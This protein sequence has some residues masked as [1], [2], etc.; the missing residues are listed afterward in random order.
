ML[1]VFVSL[2][3]LTVAMA[4]TEC[5]IKA[6]DGDFNY[7]PHSG[8]GPSNWG[9]MKGYEMCSK[10]TTQ[11]P[12]DFPADVSYAPLTNGPDPKGLGGMMTLQGK[13][14]NFELYCKNPG[15]CGYTLFAGKNFSVVNI[16]FHA[17][18]EHKLNGVQYPLEAHVVHA[19]DD[20]QLAVISTMFQYL[21]GDDYHSKLCRSKPVE[22][23]TNLLMSS[24]FKNINQGKTTFFVNIKTIIN[25][26]LGY[27]SYLG[28]LTTPPCT[29]GVTFFMAND[30]KYINPRQ[31]HMYNVTA[32]ANFDGNNR[33]TQPLNGRQIVC[34]M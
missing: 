15:E 12:V 10:G 26:P 8:H 20:G 19:S 14:S 5:R 16:H 34:F 6:K 25:Q 28:S 29:E 23:G 17:P 9:D 21:D 32:G 13:A 2:T 33:P 22:C 3:I 7:D 30:V 24:I 1:I 4:A 11:S 18:S 31:V 27:C